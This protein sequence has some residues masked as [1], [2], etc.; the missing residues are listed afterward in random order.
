M[1]PEGDTDDIPSWK[2][3]AACLG[4]L[5][6]YLESYAHV[7]ASDSLQVPELL[8]KLEEEIRNVRAF[9]K[10]VSEDTDDISVALGLCQTL[11]DICRKSPAYQISSLSA[12]LPVAVRNQRMSLYYTLQ[13]V[14]S[15]LGSIYGRMQ[16]DHLNA[17]PCLTDSLRNAAATL[18]RKGIMANKGIWKAT[19]VERALFHNR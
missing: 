13:S 11:G 14:D 15:N 6:D 8:L 9:S 12:S 10:Q 1:L 16:S 18:K 19:Q 4:K 17:L 2:M 5:A 3:M 7:G